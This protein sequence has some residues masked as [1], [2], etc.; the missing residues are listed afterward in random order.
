MEHYQLVYGSNSHYKLSINKEQENYTGLVQLK[1]SL[2][3]KANVTFKNNL[4]TL[5]FPY[6]STFTIRLSGNYNENDKI[7]CR[8]KD[9][10]LM[11]T[12]LILN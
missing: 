5:S 8:A 1:D 6:D 3:A 10:T 12:G 9:N 7:I 2:K 4:L 11:A